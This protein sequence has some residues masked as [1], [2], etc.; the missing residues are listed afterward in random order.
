MAS[1]KL[2]TLLLRD[3][4]ITLGQLEEGL[5]AQILAGGRL[6]TNLVEL[7]F[8]DLNLLGSSLARVHGLPLANHERFEA[9]PREA[10]ARMPAALAL[11]HTAF[12]LGPE[13]RSPDTLGVALADPDKAAIAA[14]AAKIG[15][16]VAPYVAPE[17]RI[18][19]HIE[20]AYGI[21]RSARYVRPT[22]P[23]A[24]AAPVE[25]RRTHGSSRPAPVR[26][27]PRRPKVTTPPPLDAVGAALISSVA[28]QSA[29]DGATHRDQIAESVM[30]FCA[31]RFAI[32]VLC[33]LRSHNAIGWRAQGPSGEPIPIDQLVL[34]LS[35][36]S[37]FQVAHDTGQPYRGPAP[38]PGRPIERQLL[39]EL[40]LALDPDDLAVI[41]I[42]VKKRVVNLLYVHAAPGTSL[43]DR[44]LAELTELTQRT[45]AAYLRLIQ[46]A[47]D[48]G[49]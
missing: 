40:G 42:V 35:A 25:R 20:R 33:I 44:H 34:S 45:A 19:Y 49:A 31:H 28:V 29:I 4:V 5:R 11:E 41:P 24:I 46:A 16:P 8:L 3:A 39:M 2:G 26:L 30:Q 7:G 37:A 23:K 10:I 1:M 36:A 48:A 17:L 43:D 38:S 47:R 27:E 18:L 6:G 15:G 12:P 13:L 22:D 21:K 32:S 9:A 14:I